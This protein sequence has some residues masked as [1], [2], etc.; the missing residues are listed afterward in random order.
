[1]ADPKSFET[2]STRAKA[3]LNDSVLTEALKSIADRAFQDW[4]DSTSQEHDKRVS[5]WHR[6][7]AV[8]SLRNELEGFASDAAVRKF[9]KKG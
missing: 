2:R 6:F 4:A 1:M 3:L 5:A 7:Q 9:N 8:R